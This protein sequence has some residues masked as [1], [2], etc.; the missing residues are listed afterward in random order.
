MIYLASE[1]PRF[2]PACG[3]EQSD[4]S[5]FFAGASAQCNCGAMYQYVES[6]TLVEASQLNKSGD[7]HRY[8]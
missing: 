8:A 5:D 1:Y 6:K 3:K 4:S 2:C 7:L